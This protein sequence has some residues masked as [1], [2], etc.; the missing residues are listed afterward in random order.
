MYKKCIEVTGLP[1]APL[2]IDKSIKAT[3]ITDFDEYW[4]PK[5]F[6]LQMTFNVI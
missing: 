5:C 4:K 2:Y 3:I 6:Y 1:K